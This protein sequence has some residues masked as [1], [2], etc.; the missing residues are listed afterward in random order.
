MYTHLLKKRQTKTA[1]TEIKLACKCI[2]MT[3]EKNPHEGCLI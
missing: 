3:R 1:I 2:K